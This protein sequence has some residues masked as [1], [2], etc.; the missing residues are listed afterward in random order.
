MYVEIGKSQTPLD[1]LQHIKQCHLERSEH[2]HTDISQIQAFS[3]VPKGVNLFDSLL[4]LENYPTDESLTSKVID[5]F[6]FA[7]ISIIYNLI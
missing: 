1:L 5:L 4:V 3:Q 2:E 7:F 6:T